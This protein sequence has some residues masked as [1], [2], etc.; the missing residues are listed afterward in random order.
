MSNPGERKERAHCIEEAVRAYAARVFGLDPCRVRA[1]KLAGDAS[2][3]QYFRVYLPDG[4][5]YVVAR[6]PEPFDP[7][8]HPYCDVT[9]LFLKAGLPVPT[10]FDADGERGMMLL[11]DLGDVRLQDWLPTARPDEQR[12]AYREAIQLILR[13]QGATRLADECGSIAARLAF[14]VEKLDWELRFFFSN[15]FEKYLGLSLAPGQTERL[16]A[17]FLEIAAELAAIP[18]VLT[19]RDFHSRNLM[20]YRGRLYI[21]DHQDARLGP[22]SYDLASLL[23]DP[24]VELDDALI[25][26]M[27]EFFLEEKSRAEA[28]WGQVERRAAFRRELDLM[29]LQR[30]LKATGTYAYQAAVVGNPVYKPYIPRALQ[31]AARALFRLGRFPALRKTFEEIIAPALL[32]RVA[33]EANRQ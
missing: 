20:W 28:T 23:G 33:M 8:T 11:E 13:I 18:R 21:I 25:E 26:A 5:H 14:D 19:H 6:Y 22:P 24:Y 10:I 3:R 27:I 30:L 29:A 31:R 17:E 4:R 15:F 16:H 9:A 1:K 7:T 12:A 32:E 2:L